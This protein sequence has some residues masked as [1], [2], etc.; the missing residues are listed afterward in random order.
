MGVRAWQGTTQDLSCKTVNATN[1]SWSPRK[2]TALSVSYWAATSAWLSSKKAC[3]EEASISFVIAGPRDSERKG[4]FSKSSNNQMLSSNKDISKWG[5]FSSKIKRGQLNTTFH[6]E[7]EVFWEGNTEREGQAYKDK[8]RVFNTGLQYMNNVLSGCSCHC[9]P[10]ALPLLR[11]SLHP[12]AAAFPA[13]HFGSI[14]GRGRPLWGRSLLWGTTQEV[15]QLTGSS[16]GLV[17]QRGT[18]VLAE[19]LRLSPH[20]GRTGGN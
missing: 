16:C 1:S 3:I 19:G 14:Q 10:P 18:A 11:N 7:E 12:G 15:L 6:S 13:R 20:T 5:G 2:S 8:T 4:I 17:K 9:H